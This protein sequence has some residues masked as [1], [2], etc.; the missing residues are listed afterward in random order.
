MPQQNPVAL[1]PLSSNYQTVLEQANKWKAELEVARDEMLWLQL[2]N[3]QC[4]D[5]LCMA[6]ADIDE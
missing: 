4:L 1:P 2:Q 5:A 6:G 3:S